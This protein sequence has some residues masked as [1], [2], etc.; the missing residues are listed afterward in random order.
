MLDVAPGIGPYRVRRCGRSFARSMHKASIWARAVFD[1]AFSR[2][3]VMFFSDPVAAL[4]EIRRSLIAARTL[5]LRLLGARFGENT[6]ML[7]PLNAPRA[8]AFLRRRRPAA[9]GSL[10]AGPVCVFAT[11][12]RVAVHLV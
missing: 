10:G 9:A 7:A 3:G 8:R 11:P 12:A 6:W 1:A 5:G 2:F 4:F